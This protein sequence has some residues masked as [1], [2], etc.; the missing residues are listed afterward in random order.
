[1]IVLVSI[2]L[3]LV[4]WVI[5]IYRA[6]IGSCFSIVCGYMAEGYDA[7]ESFVVDV[8]NKIPSYGQLREGF[9]DILKLKPFR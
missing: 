4:G 5:Y 1:M 8:W 2:H 3:C 7:C 9:I 6:P